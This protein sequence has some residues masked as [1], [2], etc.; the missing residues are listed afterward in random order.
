MYSQKTRDN[1][2][3]CSR[4][5]SDLGCWDFSFLAASRLPTITRYVGIFF[6]Q[7]LEIFAFL[8]LF[9]QKSIF[10]QYT[11]DNFKHK[12]YS[13]FLKL[14]KIYVFSGKRCQISQCHP[15]TTYD[16]QRWNIHHNFLYPVGIS[17]LLERTVW[18]L[19][20]FTFEVFFPPSP[21]CNFECERNQ[22]FF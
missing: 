22:F 15:S 8:W 6:R 11:V 9:C 16:R 21:G 19:L 4:G 18:V 5:G 3:G 7:A 12:S 1:I 13:K 14:V 2:Q 20:L 17:L 10:G